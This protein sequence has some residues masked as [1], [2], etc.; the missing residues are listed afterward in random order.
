MP[1]CGSTW[2]TLFG[3]LGFSKYRLDMSTVNRVFAFSASSVAFATCT[4]QSINSTKDIMKSRNVAPN[5][6]TPTVWIHERKKL[7]VHLGPFLIQ[8]H[9]DEKLSVTAMGRHK[10]F[11]VPQNV[12]KAPNTAPRSPHEHD[13]GQNPF[14]GLSSILLKTGQPNEA[15]FKSVRSARQQR[16]LEKLT[17]SSAAVLEQVADTISSPCC[18]LRVSTVLESAISLFTVS[19]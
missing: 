6:K 3:T 9:V 1:I 5:A 17:A 7:T 16:E 15:A 8:F 10:S 14:L 4:I 12:I 18:T 13:L 11:V 2:S 19:L